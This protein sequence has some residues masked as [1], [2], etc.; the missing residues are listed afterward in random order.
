MYE[1]LKPLEKM[2]EEFA[3]ENIKDEVIVT[4]RESEQENIDT[5]QIGFLI[6]KGLSYKLNRKKTVLGKSSDVELCI[7]S[8]MVSRW[9][10]TIYRKENGDYYIRDNLTTNGT[11]ING[12]RIPSGEQMRI[13]SGNEI[14]VANV[15]FVFVQL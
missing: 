9:H 11:F 5:E 14:R 10:C 4:E 2:I 1:E 12:K 13:Y 7:K 8:A 15:K 6:Y 3:V